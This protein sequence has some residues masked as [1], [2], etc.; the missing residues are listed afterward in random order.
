[1]PEGFPESDMAP[2]AG[3]GPPA[4]APPAPAVEE[5]PAPEGPDV[6]E[7]LQ[8]LQAAYEEQQQLLQ[9]LAPVAEYMQN[10]PGPPE[11]S[12]QQMAPPDPWSENYASEMEA[13]LEA[14]DAVRLAPYR[15]TMQSQQLEELEGRAR[16]MIADVQAEKGELI[17]PQYEE[18]V[19]GL[20]PSDLV[21]QFAQ[22]YSP[23]MVQRY[24]Q[25]IKAD[26]AAI[27]R[28][29]EEVKQLFEGVA[30]ANEARQANQIATLNGAP[31]EP[32]ATGIAAQQVVTTQPG[33]WDA[34]KA[35]HGLS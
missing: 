13:Y 20:D 5:S 9:T 19:K 34:F 14:R 6:A 4:D 7:Q 18:G 17:T 27:E 22:S 24:G 15:E 1:M 29:Y 32:G 25:G 21:L 30:A 33:G 23:E 31:R 26:E 11:Q 8:Q 16:D 3:L 28:A 2:G 12:Q 35:R 10:A